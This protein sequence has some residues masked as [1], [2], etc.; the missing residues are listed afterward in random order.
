M[1]RFSYLFSLLLMLLFA[2]CSSSLWL[3]SK[4]LKIYQPD[5]FI[6]FQLIIED[7]FP[8]LILEMPVGEFSV[9]IQAF[10]T[11]KAKNLLYKF[12]EEIKNFEYQQ[13]NFPLQVKAKHFAL[14]FQIIDLENEKEF[15]H[16]LDVKTDAKYPTNIGVKESNGVY[17]LRKDIKQNESLLLETSKDS[18]P[19]LFIKFYQN[20]FNPAPPPFSE[21]TLNFDYNKT[22]DQIFVL[23]N[24]AEFT[25]YKEGLYFI[26]TDSSS[27][28]GRF[29][30][31]FDEDFPKVTN[32]YQLALTIRYITKNKEF[33]K[34]LN[35]P[36]IKK[37]LD[38]FWL[39]R[40]SSQNRA[41]VLIQSYY[42][43]IQNANI[44]FTTYKEGWKTDRG[45]IYT[46]FGEPDKVTQ[47]EDYEF[48]FYGYTD[49]RESASFFFDKIKGQYLLR[50]NPALGRVWNAEVY[51]WRQGLIGE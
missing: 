28:E 17:F 31:C 44:Y 20:T 25:F 43:R 47:T 30:N 19:Q 13:N 41:R 21:T 18:I 38:E 45:M 40:S 48:W 6:P 2:N 15:R 23:K 34:I 22:P 51:E 37:E 11:Y 42:N 49:R 9:T 7:G 4:P 8:I 33:E 36:E 16:I 5:M 46:I 39:A 1:G 14:E 29:I 12:E 32:A 24:K 50:R 27:T 10:E 3:S 26:Q 35:A